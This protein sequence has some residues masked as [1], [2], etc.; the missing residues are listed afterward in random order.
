MG[1]SSPAADK[2]MRSQGVRALPSFHFVRAVP[3]QIELSLRRMTPRLSRGAKP[4]PLRRR[5]PSIFPPCGR[6]RHPN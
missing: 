3:A 6:R 1:D 2:L 5:R 4:K